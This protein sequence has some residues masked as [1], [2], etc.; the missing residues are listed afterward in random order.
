M[1]PVS[2]APSLLSLST[3]SSTSSIS[4]TNKKRTT[5]R[6]ISTEDNKLE[7]HPDYFLINALQKQNEQQQLQQMDADV[8]FANSIVPILKN[9]SAFKNRKAKI[10]I[11]QLLLKYEFDKDS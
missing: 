10:D 2:P 4:T 9:L 5:K 11:Q 6:N 3:S 8:S 7:D 1:P